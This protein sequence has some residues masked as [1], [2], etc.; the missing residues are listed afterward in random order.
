MAENLRHKD[1]PCFNLLGTK[2]R[3]RIA[4]CISSV[5]PQATTCIS[6]SH[7]YVVRR[8]KANPWHSGNKK[9]E[10]N[11]QLGTQISLLEK[12]NRCSRGGSSY[13]VLPQ[14]T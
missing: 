4:A 5:P 9:G 6:L 2:G 14:A 7:N 1:A 8:T 3:I 10:M 13:I 11:F 12:K